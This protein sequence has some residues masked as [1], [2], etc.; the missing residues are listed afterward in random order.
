LDDCI[1]CPCGKIYLEQT[2]IK[3]DVI[4]SSSQIGT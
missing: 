2:T 1:H 3:I 4:G